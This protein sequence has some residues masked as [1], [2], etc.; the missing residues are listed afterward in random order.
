[1]GRYKAKD[2]STDADIFILP[3]TYRVEIEDTETGKKAEGV[4]FTR[5][6]AKDNAWLNLKSGKT[7]D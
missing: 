4:G 6:E 2:T 5:E 1:M 3:R 7:K